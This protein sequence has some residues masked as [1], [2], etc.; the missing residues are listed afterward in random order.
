MP[1]HA[2][3]F[4]NFFESTWRCC[5]LLSGFISSLISRNCGILVS[6]DMF[7]SNGFDNTICYSGYAAE[8]LEVYDREN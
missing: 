8:L 1:D 3:P 7:L 6:E 2:D 4:R 5:S